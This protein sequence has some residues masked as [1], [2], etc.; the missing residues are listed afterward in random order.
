[1]VRNE[2]PGRSNRAALQ[3][4]E[5]STHMANESNCP[6]SAA[7]RSGRSNRDWWPNQL[8]LSALHTNHPSGNP[9]GDDFN[10]GDECKALH[11]HALKKDIEAVMTNSQ[12]WWPAD[13]GHYGPLFIR[14]AWHSAGT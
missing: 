7:S 14:M 6:F 12:A 9:M 1:E 13:F 2:S 4:L 8:N 11:L 5:R 10:Y 3:S